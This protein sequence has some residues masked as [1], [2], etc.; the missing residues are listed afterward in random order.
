MRL[1]IERFSAT[2]LV[3]PDHCRVRANIRGRTDADVFERMRDA[4]TASSSY[5]GFTAASNAC[6]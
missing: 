5:G 4:P 6:S 3:L 1:Y 2:K